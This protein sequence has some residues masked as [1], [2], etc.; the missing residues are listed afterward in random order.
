MA[1]QSLLVPIDIFDT[2]ED[3]PKPAAHQH[4]NRPRQPHPISYLPTRMTQLI[5]DNYKI[6]P[7]LFPP[8]QL[9]LTLVI[10]S[11]GVTTPISFLSWGQVES[12]RLV[13]NQKCLL[14]SNKAGFPVCPKYQQVSLRATSYMIGK[15]LC[16]VELT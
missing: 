3:Q 10:H 14:R 2:S 4:H 15:S 8:K 16:C 7:Q 5:L 9:L 13:T 12:P 6:H 1:F 11:S